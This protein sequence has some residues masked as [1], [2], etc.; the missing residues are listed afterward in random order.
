[1]L[2]CAEYFSTYLAH[3]KEDKHYIYVNRPS[4]YQCI[5]LYVDLRP[6]SRR[7]SCADVPLYLSLPPALIINMSVR[8]SEDRSPIVYSVVLLFASES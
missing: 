5:I 1:M 2:S 3:S 6:Q 7:E 4:S 8:K